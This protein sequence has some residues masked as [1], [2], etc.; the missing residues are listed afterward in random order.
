MKTK[1]LFTAAVCMI[2]TATSSCAQPVVQL[3]AMIVDAAGNRINGGRVAGKVVRGNP[4]YV[5]SINAGRIWYRTTPIAA[6]IKSINVQGL[7][8]F[9]GARPKDYIE[10]VELYEERKYQVA[11]QAFRRVKAKYAKFTEVDN[12][13]PALAGLY[14]LD[15]LRK[16]KQY[17]KLAQAEKVYADGQFLTKESDKYQVEIYQLW[18]SLDAKQYQFIEK[19]Y[20]LKWQKPKLPGNLRAQVEYLYG[21]SQEALK[22]PGEALIAYC[23]A[24]NADFAG[25]EVLTLEAIASSLNLIENDKEAQEVRALWDNGAR[26]LIK[27]KVNTM[28][29]MRLL[30]ACALV[31]V[32]DKLAYSGFDGE[33]KAVMLPEKYNK[34]LKYTKVAGEKF[35]D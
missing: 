22:K 13:F 18:T 34:Y 21:K 11:L 3:K 6:Q 16:L 32:H 27:P 1:T 26:D 2:L 33:G 8:S 14:E 20:K 25:S 10:A 15:C 19:E 7:T 4:V 12:S 29:Y 23:K 30:E 5:E 31:K 28:P 35:L 17:N 24:M 9:Y